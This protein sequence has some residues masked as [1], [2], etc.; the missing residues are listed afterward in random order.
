MLHVVAV[1]AMLALGVF[2]WNASSLAHGEIPQH[3][4]VLQSVKEMSYELVSN[5]R[6]LAVYVADHGNAVSIEGIVGRI[7]ISRKSAHRE[8]ELKPDGKDRLIA[9]GVRVSDA[10]TVTALLKMPSGRE[11]VVRFPAADAKQTVSAL[12]DCAPWPRLGEDRTTSGF[13]SVVAAVLNARKL[14]D[15]RCTSQAR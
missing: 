10:D 9:D 4:G 13:E 5:D 1:R 6:G 8:A 14:L 2:C 3:G 7:V 15:A 11:V 12:P